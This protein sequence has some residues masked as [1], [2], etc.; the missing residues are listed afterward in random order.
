M[1]R[2][3]GLSVVTGALALL[4]AACGAQVEV[5]A[6]PVAVGVAP[7]RPTCE[8]V[9]PMMAACPG[10]GPTC[11]QTCAAA[12]NLSAEARCEATLQA[13]LDCLSGQSANVCAAS[14]TVCQQVTLSLGACITNYCLHPRVGADTAGWCLQ[15]A[16]G[17]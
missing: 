12:R 16:A 1:V 2:V 10:K 5:A 4:G 17:F 9:C 7:G 11:P 14:Q 3:V 13:E 8:S 15:A 6:G